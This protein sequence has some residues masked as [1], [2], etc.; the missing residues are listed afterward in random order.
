[1]KYFYHFHKGV[2][3]KKLKPFAFFAG[4]IAILAPIPTSLLAAVGAYKKNA[5][6]IIPCVFSQFAQ[7]FTLP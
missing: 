1:M 6:L 5:E 3:L 7:L 2:G 4:L